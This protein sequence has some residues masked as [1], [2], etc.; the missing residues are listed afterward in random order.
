MV[1]ELGAVEE[2]SYVR[3]ELTFCCGGSITG[4]QKGDKSQHSCLTVQYLGQQ[5]AEAHQKLLL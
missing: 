2:G 5:E 1:V 4:N 3:K